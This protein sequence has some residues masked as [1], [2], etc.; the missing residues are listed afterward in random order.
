MEWT[1]ACPEA[2]AIMLFGAFFCVGL[3]VA[4]AWREVVD[5]LRFV[6][7]TLSDWF[8]RRL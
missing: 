1:T 3:L 2:S 7:E 4:C 6:C 5:F 8:A